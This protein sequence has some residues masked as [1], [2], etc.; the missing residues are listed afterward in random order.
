MAFELRDRIALVTGGTRQTGATIAQAL[1]ESGAHVILNYFHDCDGAEATAQRMLKM[2]LS[3]ETV[4]ASV[5]K[6]DEVA[7]MFDDLA[8]KHGGLDI[9]VNNAAFGVFA[10]L[11]E[12]SERDW[13]RVHSV[14]FHGARLCSAAALPLMR[15][16]G[17]GSI[18]N[19]SS[20][21]SGQ[22]IENYAAVGTAKAALEALTRYLAVAYGPYGI[23]VNTASFGPLDGPTF[24]LFPEGERLLDASAAI[25]PLGRHGTIEDLA[26]LVLMLA[27]DESRWMTGQVLLADGGLSLS[28]PGLSPWVLRAQAPRNDGLEETPQATPRITVTEPD[29]AS[30]TGMTLEGGP[31]EA[32]RV[33][34][35]EPDAPAEIE[36]AI[37]GMGLALP[38]ASSPEEF[39]TL[40]NT[41]RAVFS[42]PGD[43]L[44]INQFHDN[45]PRA[46]D[47]GYARFGGYLRQLC[48]HPVLRAELAHHGGDAYEHSTRWLRH[49][50]LQAVEPVRLDGAARCQLVVGL[51]PDGNQHLEESIVVEAAVR[52][53][54]EYANRDELLA[55]LRGAYRFAVDDLRTVLPHRVPR[56]A[57]RGVL[58]STT[59]VRVVDT[60]CS[61][62]LYAIDLGAKALRS[63]D[64]DVAVCGGAF[65]LT[66]R[67]SV[68]FSKLGGMSPT[69]EV[70]SF[71]RT[72][73]GTVFADGAAV[74]VLK[75]LDR[76]IADGD[77]VLGTVLGFGGSADG[78]GKAINAPNS[79]GQRLAVER[80]LADAGVGPAD[81]DWVVAHATGTPSG[82]AT[83][84]STLRGVADDKAP[85]FV[86]SN[87]AVVGHTGWSAGAVSVI[88]ALLALRHQEIPAQPDFGAPPD[89]A[90]LDHAL[91]IP[92]RSVPWPRRQ[93]HRRT[94]AVSSFGFGGTNAHLVLAE[95]PSGEQPQFGTRI[96]E[97]KA[98]DPV[99]IVA[100]NAHLPGEPS[101]DR[102]VRWLR[103]E[104]PP[105]A[106]RFGDY[107]L[108]EPPVVRLTPAALR[109]IDREQLMIMRC[110]RELTESNPAL[111]AVPDRTGVF[112]GHAGMTRSGGHYALRTH[113]SNLGKVLDR[114]PGIVRSAEARTALVQRFKELTVP[115]NEDT[116]P[117]LMPN[118][119]AARVNVLLNLRGMN[120]S[121]DAGLD[122]TLA[123]LD[124]AAR[125]LDTGDIDIALVFGLNAQTDVWA[126][127][128]YGRPASRTAPPCE[129]AF[130][131]AVT[132]RSV[133][134]ASGLPVVAQVEPLTGRPQQD[135]L[136]TVV[137]RDDDERYLGACS[138][139]ALLRALVRSEPRVRLMGVEEHAPSFLISKEM[140]T[141]APNDEDH[142]VR[143]H[144]LIMRA[145]P[146]VAVREPVS[147]IPAG[148]LVLTDDLATAA[149]LSGSG[150]T[151]LTPLP[152]PVPS[153]VLSVHPVDVATYRAVVAG[154]R[155]AHV[156]VIA[157]GGASGQVPESLLELHDLCEIALREH[158]D[159][160]DDGGSF[161]VLVPNGLS[162]GIPKPGTGLFTGLSASLLWD[163]PSGVGYTVV[164]DDPDVK[165]GLALLAAES[166][167]ARHRGIAYYQGKQRFEPMVVRLSA[168]PETPSADLMPQD[169]VMVVTGG[170]RGITARMVAALA[171][172]TRPRVWLLGSQPLAD[173][174]ELAMLS[175]GRAQL[176]EAWHDQDPDMSIATLNRRYT[177][178]N[179]AADKQA[180]IE[181]LAELCGPDN[182]QYLQCD[183]RNQAAVETAI[184][185]VLSAEGKVDVVVHGAGVVRGAVRGDFLDIFRTVR[186]SKVRGYLNLKKALLSAPPSRWYNV[187][188]IAS[189]IGV[190]GD[191]GY[192]TGNAFLATAATHAQAGGSDEFTVDWTLWAEDGFAADPVFLA[193]QQRRLTLT[194]ISTA[195]G[196]AHTVEEF[197]DLRH[198][199]AA[200]VLYLG[201][202]E[203]ALLDRLDQHKT[204][205]APRGR[206]FLTSAP[207]EATPDHARWSLE[208]DLERHRYLAHHIV[209]GRPTM[210]GAIF[211]ELASEAAAVLVPGSKVRSIRDAVFL[212]F[213]RGPR[214]SWPKMVKV[215]ARVCERGLEQTSV[216]VTVTGDVRAPDGTLLAERTHCRMR[217][218]LGAPTDPIEICCPPRDGGLLI[219][220]PYLLPGSPVAMSGPFLAMW[221]PRA[222]PWGVSAKLDLSEAAGSGIFG[223]FLVPSLAV[224]GLARLAA[225]RVVNERMHVAGLAAIG[226][227]DLHLEHNDVELDQAFG[228]SLTLHHHAATTTRGEAAH[229]TAS[230]GR[231]LARLHH[232]RSVGRGTFDP[233]TG[234][235][236]A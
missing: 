125:Y 44:D 124:T 130:G 70:R 66:A 35:P 79:A 146:P 115:S 212:S 94:V 128:A 194:G 200:E 233:A 171:A 133:A 122:S 24:R 158:Q 65:A 61:S 129:G 41:G 235:F 214:D 12:L 236:V 138:A 87:K 1:A 42:E 163:L 151:V 145:S 228:H 177:R 7:T 222:H 210:P 58:P 198:E 92:R 34:L 167:L 112:L 53:L 102:V 165:S 172:R 190:P 174:A 22:V 38:E 219:P 131:F 100:W 29:T 186:D 221:Q 78:R 16:R 82:D 63:G 84:L 86:S 150:R 154:Q 149:V 32:L 208:L 52:E 25:T 50:L 139:L 159:Q 46:E 170:A 14:T 104:Q 68:L 15:T 48:P 31:T 127:A 182:V 140:L 216:A 218:V 215:D 230:D 213:L 43:R 105:P 10:P 175:L 229:M 30:E 23:R 173:S 168:P 95:P 155:I 81:I 147:A 116:L 232:L 206:F 13:Q 180:V 109:S 64:T 75:R 21:G 224:D 203:H 137:A 226:R 77:E 110:A 189:V 69:G 83:E 176:I 126:A 106:E 183:V 231:L 113:L 17:G 211:L 59:D 9:L 143:R 169:P 3:V 74:V 37:V 120:M 88:H 96:T 207:F 152:G 144:G 123:A 72:A 93:N 187:G 234:Q 76:A 8:A 85:W 101:A 97:T 99:V 39:W 225:L 141:P 223:Q 54:S 166:A 40:L 20:S 188:S 121:V 118:V 19:V 164:T 67:M 80:A 4:R 134:R 111:L 162:G 204:A 181:E 91:R 71:A 47:K 201:E 103:G 192:V 6:A 217:V 60:A 196:T 73:N 136:A 191:S 220:D 98:D 2:G 142:Q 157:T 62:S 90:L 156:R 179:Q 202:T 36:I 49:A 184:G 153:G 199:A 209:D 51:T 26:H 160:L 135:D 148:S 227:L 18:V 119:T 57:M 132:R 45:D 195:E 55:H 185:T 5:A 33:G 205:G 27:S 56:V 197:A 117:G 193:H 108:P 114:F 107:Q 161:A 28:V 89:A 178:L 11:D